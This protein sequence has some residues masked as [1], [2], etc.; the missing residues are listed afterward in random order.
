LRL[1]ARPDPP[2]NDDMSGEPGAR[3]YAGSLAAAALGARKQIATIATHRH[4]R[5]GCKA[6]TWLSG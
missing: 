6:L 4:Q 3:V 2:P 1:N 5:R